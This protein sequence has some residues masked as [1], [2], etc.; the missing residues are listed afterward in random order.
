[1]RLRHL[2]RLSLTEIA[3]RM[4]KRRWRWRNLIKRDMQ[5]LPALRPGVIRLPLAA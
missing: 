3:E 1:V 5:T 2:Q 4:N